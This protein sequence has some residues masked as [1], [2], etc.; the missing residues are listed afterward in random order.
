MPKTKIIA[1]VGPSSQDPEVLSRMIDLGLSCVRINSAHITSGFIG[2]MKDVVSELNRKKGT[3]VAIMVDLKGPEL[4]TSSFTG[5]KKK[6]ISGKVFK[7][8]PEATK[9][10]EIGINHPSVISSLKSGDVVYMSDGRV[11]FNVTDILKDQA[12][13]IAEDDAEIRDRS[14][15]NIPGRILD[16][17]TLTER[18]RTFLQEGIE[19]AVDYFALSFVQSKDN[20]QNLQKTIMES[21][22]SQGIVSKIET[23]SGYQNIEEISAA[24]DVIMV[25]RGD[26][27]VEL[28]LTE[29]S[30]AQKN[31]I[32]HAHRRG[33]PT[34]V[35]TQMLESMVQSDSPTRAEVSDVT[36]AILDNTDSLMLSEET[37]MGKFPVEAVGYLGRISEYVES[38]RKDFSEPEEFIGNRV[39]YSIAVASKTIAIDASAEGIIAF[40]RTGNTARMISATRPTVPVYGVVSSESIARK[41]NLFRGITP[42]Y[43]PMENDT[44]TDIYEMTQNFQNMMKIKKGLRYVVTSGAPY[45]FSGGTNDVRVITTGKYLGVGHTNGIS[46]DG[47]VSTSTSPRGEILF[48]QTADKIPQEISNYKGIIC[49]GAVGSKLREKL[50][51]AGIALLANTKMF[52][53]LIDNESVFMDGYTGIIVS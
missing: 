51:D 14:R 20:V 17:G 36:N 47:S 26:L 5:G 50:K 21:G 29:V 33:K 44:T 49:C 38:Q 8:V 23:K 1:T 41:L 24:S 19:N 10:D 27:G 7:L 16:L 25:A 43:L 37:A 34:I 15:I 52:Y 3:H 46:A 45:F 11:S 28:P 18:D 40:T 6:I 48:V 2:K 53:E 30:L 4:R 31:I 22:G 13:I 32:Y 12:V 39:A 35:A 9:D 42:V